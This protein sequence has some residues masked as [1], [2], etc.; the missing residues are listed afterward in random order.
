MVDEASIMECQVPRSRSICCP[1][2]CK[3]TYR[4]HSTRVR[5]VK[6]RHVSGMV[7]SWIISGR[8][9]RIVTTYGRVGFLSLGF[10]SFLPAALVS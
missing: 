1:L 2:A 5:F 6:P 3:Q 9:E 4:N 7:G 10:A 8:D